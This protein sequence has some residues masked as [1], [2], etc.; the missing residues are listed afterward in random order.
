MKSSLVIS[1]FFHSSWKRTTV[2]SACSCG[3]IPAFSAAC[4]TFCPCSSVPVRKKVGTPISR[5]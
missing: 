2:R 5:W 4:C 3:V 1:S